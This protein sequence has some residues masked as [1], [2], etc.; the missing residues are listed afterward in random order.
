MF[1]SFILPSVSFLYASGKIHSITFK[2][3]LSGQL[4]VFATMAVVIP[5]LLIVLLSAFRFCPCFR[6][7]I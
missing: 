5:F 2:C 3:F 7:F 1:V 6:I 4:S